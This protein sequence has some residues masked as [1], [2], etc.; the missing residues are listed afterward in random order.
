MG[1]PEPTNVTNMSMMWATGSW[2]VGYLTSFSDSQAN[3]IFVGRYT[4][5]SQPNYWRYNA[6]AVLTWSRV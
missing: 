1:W 6:N 2:A 3:G 5:G 4:Y